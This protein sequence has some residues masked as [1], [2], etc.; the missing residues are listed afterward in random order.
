LIKR[1]KIFI[2]T[3]NNITVKNKKCNVTHTGWSNVIL[4][5]VVSF[6]VT[7]TSLEFRTSLVIVSDER[8]ISAPALAN[9]KAQIILGINQMHLTADWDTV[10]GV[11][12]K[13]DIISMIIPV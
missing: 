8:E 10:V 6:K 12:L 3:Y 13:A 5:V 7:I 1:V 2:I 11:S 9:M 4:S